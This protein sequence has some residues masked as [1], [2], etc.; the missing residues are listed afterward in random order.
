MPGLAVCMCMCMCVCVR[1]CVCHEELKQIPENTP[2]SS[3]LTARSSPD[4]ERR[5]VLRCE[6]S[7]VFP[8]TCE[9]CLAGSF[10]VFLTLPGSHYRR[11]R[12]ARSQPEQQE[13]VHSN[14]GRRE[15]ECSCCCAE[16]RSGA[17]GRTL[18]AGDFRIK[19]SLRRTIKHD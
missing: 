13:E 3:A 5:Q 17:P 14:T 7:C 9:S 10:V 12:S 19:G 15:R 6:S 8:L 18:P 4:N 16:R 1:V 2:A 11:T